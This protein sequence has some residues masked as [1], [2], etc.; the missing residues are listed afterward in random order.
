VGDAKEDH[1]L[2][3]SQVLAGVCEKGCVMRLHDSEND[4]YL[5]EG[6]EPVSI[7]DGNLYYDGTDQPARPDADAPPVPVAPAPKR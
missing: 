4:E 1:I 2:K 7:E 5:L 3:P 6:P